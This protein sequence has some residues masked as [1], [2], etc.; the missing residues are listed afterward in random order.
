MTVGVAD[1]RVSTSPGEVLVTYS[2]GSCIGV[3]VYDGVARV[4]GLLHF[5]LPDAVES[6][7]PNPALYGD[8]GLAVMLSKLERAGARRENLRVCF[9][10]GANML[11]NARCFDIGAKN[12]ASIRTQLLGRG[13]RAEAKDVGGTVPRTMTMRMSDG[14]VALRTAA[15]VK[16]LN[17][18]PQCQ[19][20]FRAV[21]IVP[22]RPTG[23]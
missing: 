7:I 15:G 4:G 6:E 12:I 21:D 2:L 23:T 13:L 10:G 3:T 14:A 19:R 9:A 5:Q 8:S 1:L 11:S 16:L 18:R 20:D 22:P 17:P